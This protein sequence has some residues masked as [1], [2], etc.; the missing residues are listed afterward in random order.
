MPNAASESQSQKTAR[1]ERIQVRGPEH[2]VALIEQASLLPPSVQRAIGDPGGARPEDI[3]ALQHAAG[4]EAVERL[5]ENR[6]SGRSEPSVGDLGCQVAPLTGGEGTIQRLPWRKS[7]GKADERQTD[8]RFANV[9]RAGE[10]GQ[11]GYIR[12]L[13]GTQESLKPE[14]QAWVKAH[15]Q[16]TGAP[17]SAPV[18]PTG[19]AYKVITFDQW[20]S[21]SSRRGRFRSAALLEIDGALAAYHAAYSRSPKERLDLLNELFDKISAWQ[22]SKRDEQGD[23]KSGR[24]AAVAELKQWVI[25]EQNAMV[26]KGQAGSAPTSAVAV[27]SA[28]E[29]LYS[30][31][32]HELHSFLAKKPTVSN[33]DAVTGYW[34]RFRTEAMKIEHAA[35]QLD[36]SDDAAFNAHL[37][38]LGLREAMRAFRTVSYRHL[39]TPRPDSKKTNLARIRQRLDRLTGKLKGAEGQDKGS[40]LVRARADIDQFAGLAGADKKGKGG[41]KALD[42]DEA[43][44]FELIEETLNALDLSTTMMGYQG[45]GGKGN[46]GFQEFW[47]TSSPGTE[48]AFS[49]LAPQSTSAQDVVSGVSD[50]ENALGGLESDALAVFGIVQTWQKYKDPKATAEEKAEA[51]QQLI[52]QM[53]QTPLSTIAN[54]LKFT[55]GALTARRGDTGSVAESNFGFTAS[56]TD[57]STDVKMAGDFAGLFAGVIDSIGKV[58]DLVKFI[59]SGGGKS[60]KEQKR[61]TRKDFEAVGNL[62]R[63]YTGVVASIAGNFKAAAKLGYQIAGHG[64]LAAEK[65][66]EAATVTNLGGVVPGLK[67]ATGVMQAIQQGYKLVRIGIRRLALTKKIKELV[68]QGTGDLKQVEATEFAHGALVKRSNRIGINLGHALASIVAAGFDLSGIGLA[69]GMVISLSSSAMKIGQIALRKGKQFGRD[70]KAKQRAEKDEGRGGSESYKQWKHRKKLQ[71]AKTSRWQQFKTAIDIKFTFNWDKSSENKESNNREVALEI[72]RMDDTVIYDAIGVT[73]ALE[74]ESD[75]AERLKIVLGALKKRD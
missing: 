21:K 30:R 63:K 36:Q 38:T 3:L 28:V 70:R 37:Y 56:G 62:L 26:E 10:V 60:A 74:G 22:N 40:F 57:V 14:E 54:V 72:L 39:G 55:G 12:H 73:D 45:T 15:V 52:L 27:I 16:T 32:V 47:S 35:T 48:K 50:M 53:S 44:D 31:G 43:P 13:V 34:Q 25:A 1:K 6:T 58:I 64:Q 65:T 33:R 2:P 11:E 24:A 18:T 42:E 49:G 20:L 19:P 41:L 23:V 51:K 46:E 4:N 67:L 8:P 66:A 29:D 5:L 69:P 61:T 17:K 7:K 75:M 9:P 71:A 68:S 59:K